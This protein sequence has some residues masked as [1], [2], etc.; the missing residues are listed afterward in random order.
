MADGSVKFIKDSINMQTWW[1][2]GT[3]N[4]GEVISS[5]AY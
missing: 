1:S 5:D 3:R 4:G 2:L